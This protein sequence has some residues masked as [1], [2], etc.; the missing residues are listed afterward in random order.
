MVANGVNFTKPWCGIAFTIQWGRFFTQLCVN[1]FTQ[2]KCV[3]FTQ[4]LSSPFLPHWCVIFT[5]FM[6]GTVFTYCCVTGFNQKWVKTFLHNMVVQLFTLHCAV[7]YTIMCND[8]ICLK[9]H[10]K[11]KHTITCELWTP[12]LLFCFKTSTTINCSLLGLFY[13]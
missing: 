10:I 12:E 2:L 3:K 9:R 7:F 13:L 6:Q 4:Q 11:D 8:S 1:Y 5:K